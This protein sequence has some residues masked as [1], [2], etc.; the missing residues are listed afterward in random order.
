MLSLSGVS[1]IFLYR[2]VT[3]M[4]KS[5]EGLSGLVEAHFP[6]QLLTGALFIFCNRRRDRVKVLYWD[7]DGFVLWY[8]RLEKG[9]FRLPGHGDTMT[10]ERRQMLALLE[11][12]TPLKYERRF[13]LK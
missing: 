6:G 11:G 3:N 7:G 2:G 10:L 9:R 5:F 12:V 4:S 8:K 1:R 13:R